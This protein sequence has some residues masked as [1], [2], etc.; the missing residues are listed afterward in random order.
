MTDIVDQGIYDPEAIECPY[1][2]Y[3]SLRDSPV[4]YQPGLGFLV[5]RYEDVLAVLLDT[6]TYSNS[7][8]EGFA[9]SR[10]TL[11]PRPPSVDAIMEEGYPECPA[12]AHTDATTHRRHRRLV[13][14]AFTPRR[15]KQF[16]TVILS[17]A[18][19]LIDRFIERGTVELLNEFS[20]PLPLTIMADALGVPRKDLPLFREWSDAL[21]GIRSRYVPEDEF[22]GRAKKWVAFQ[23][24]FGAVVD[25][26]AANPRDDFVTDLVTAGSDEDEPLNKGELMSLFAQLLEAGNE[27][28]SS[29]LN[30]AILALAV[31]EPRQRALRENPSAVTNF[32]EEIL[33]RDAPAL[34]KPRVVTKDTRIGSVD[35][36]AGSRVLVMYGSANRDE[37]VFPA[38]DE[39]DVERRNLRH[40]VTFGKGTHHCIGAPL[41]RAE[42]HIGIERLLARIGPFTLAPGFE[43]AYTGGPAFRRLQSLDLVFTPCS[44]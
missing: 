27:T 33:R 19:E 41:A 32:V 38:A 42:L 10:W 5:S 9:A 12:L 21:G 7:I 3:Q 1:P 6:E 23:R 25:D 22:I 24:Y 43:P 26:R 31:D 4:R 13:N 18:D 35:I 20:A 8:S 2:L 29:T 14:P 15:V 37:D 11:N 39:L 44:R 28:T 40:H 17:L 30:S 16:E 36:P 34:F